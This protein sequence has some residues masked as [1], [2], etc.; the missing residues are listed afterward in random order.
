MEFLIFLGFCV[1]VGMF[2]QRKGRS[3]LAWGLASV[4]ISPLLAGIVL[5]LVKD[6]SQDEAVNKVG[7]EQ[8]DIKERMAVNEVQMNQRFQHVEKEISSIKQEV[9]LLDSAS[10]A[11]PQMLEESMKKCPH[12]GESIRAVAVK[13]RYCGSA[14]E[15]VQMRECPFCK[16]LIRAD[17]TKCRF[18]RSDLTDGMVSEASSTESTT[19]QVQ[20]EVLLC[21]NCHAPIVPGT[22]FCGSCGALLKS[23]E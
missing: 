8:Q 14:L 23:E 7:M 16:E 6:L 10:Q 3:G 12:C 17:A 9:G 20:P 4:F 21:P 2:A 18:C 13:C 11:R 22:K 15:T 1:A 5:A 19:V